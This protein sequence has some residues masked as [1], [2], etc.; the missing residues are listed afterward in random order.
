MV[1][2]T[3]PVYNRLLMDGLKPLGMSKGEPEEVACVHQE[4]AMA[5]KSPSISLR[6]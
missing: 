5:S 4:K 1:P 2:T 3:K 6:S